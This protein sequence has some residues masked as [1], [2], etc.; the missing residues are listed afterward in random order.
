MPFELGLTVAWVK[1]RGRRHDWYVFEAQKCRLNKSLS[2]LDGTDH[3]VHGAEPRR[4]FRALTNA[5]VRSR[6]QPTVAQ[7]EKVYDDLK[8]AVPTLKRELRT[9][10]LFEA[11]P[12]HDLVVAGARSAGRIIASL[13]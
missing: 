3:H 11:R 9:D 4:L 10:S 5:L 13:G 6:Y 8:E 2:D 12:F 1:T 7:L